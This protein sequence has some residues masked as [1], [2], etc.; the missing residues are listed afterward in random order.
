LAAAETIAPWRLSARLS[1]QICSRRISPCLHLTLGL[2]WNKIRTYIRSSTGSGAGV[3][4]DVDKANGR[5][6]GL[7]E[8]KAGVRVRQKGRGQ[9]RNEQ[10]ASERRV[11]WLEA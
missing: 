8:R 5:V 7:A 1:G 9:A 4:I 10:S 11:S 2:V 3:E 6:I